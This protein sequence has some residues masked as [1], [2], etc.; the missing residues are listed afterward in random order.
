LPRVAHVALRGGSPAQHA[1]LLRIAGDLE[2]R[3]S[4]S[5][6]ALRG[7][8]LFVTIRSRASTLGDELPLRWEAATVA[9]AIYRGPVRFHLDN[10]VQLVYQRPDGA[11]VDAGYVW[12]QPRRQPR[13]A[14]PVDLAGAARAAGFRVLGR[15]VLGGNLG[16]ML[17][18]RGRRPAGVL[19]A[20]RRFEPALDRSFGFYVEVQ[21]GCGRVVLSVGDGSWSPLIGCRLWPCPAGVTIPPLPRR[22]PGC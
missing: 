11:S 12:T 20:W 7:R 15:R 4:I 16:G 5:R 19:A 6:I 10:R 18:F 2:G 21:N 13:R 14:P 1:E 9:Q 8:R 3:A 22:W 17:A